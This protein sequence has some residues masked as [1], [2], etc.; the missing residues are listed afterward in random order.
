M[1]SHT[2]SGDLDGCALR[3]L[4]LLAG[5]VEMLPWNSVQEFPAFAAI[6]YPS[7]Q[8]RLLYNMLTAVSPHTSLS[9]SVIVF[10]KEEEIDHLTMNFVSYGGNQ[11]SA[12]LVWGY[13]TWLYISN[14][15]PLLVQVH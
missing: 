10:P 11:I 5:L 1:L 8:V 3:Q 14:K 2:L 12:S 15:D 13:L 9:D 6:I 7:L 4:L